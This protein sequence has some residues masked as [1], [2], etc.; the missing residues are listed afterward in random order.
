MAKKNLK[1]LKYK[2]LLLEIIVVV[3]MRDFDGGF[4]GL[5]P[6]RANF[7]QENFAK[8]ALSDH[9]LAVDLIGADNWQPV[10][11]SMVDRLEHKVSAEFSNLSRAH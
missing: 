8:T 5:S 3:V 9:D 11:E 1:I 2:R 4:E 10:W 6:R 7:R